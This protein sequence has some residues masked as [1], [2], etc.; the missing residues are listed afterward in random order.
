MSYHHLSQW[1]SGQ[2]HLVVMATLDVSDGSSSLGQVAQH[3]TEVLLPHCHL[4]GHDWLQ[5]LASC[6]LQGLHP[7]RSEACSSALVFRD[8]ETLKMWLYL[9]Q[10]AGH[11]G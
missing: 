9:L 5:D 7:D 10:A 3:G 6:L 4:Q 8:V 11:T 1:H 2:Q